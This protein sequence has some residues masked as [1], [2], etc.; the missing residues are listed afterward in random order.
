MQVKYSDALNLNAISQLIVSGM[1]ISETMGFASIHKITKFVQAV[2]SCVKDT[3][4]PAINELVTKHEGKIVMRGEGDNQFQDYDFGENL[5]A[6]LKEQGELLEVEADLSFPVLKMKDFEGIV[7][8]ENKVY[9][10]SLLSKFIEEE[11]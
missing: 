3:I 8:K 9:I 11:D 4:R 10:V 1:E 5:P 6:F 7:L 2:D